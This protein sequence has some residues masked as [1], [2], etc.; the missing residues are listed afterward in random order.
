[1]PVWAHALIPLI[2]LAIMIA[3]FAFANP[4]ALFRADLPPIENLAF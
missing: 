1:L 3:V 4:L 2:A